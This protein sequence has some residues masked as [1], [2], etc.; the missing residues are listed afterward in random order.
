M[1]P[2]IEANSYSSE[3]IYKSPF[4]IK[5]LTIISEDADYETRTDKAHCF[6]SSVPRII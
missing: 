2:T 6:Y 3:R 1:Q 4:I 5:Q